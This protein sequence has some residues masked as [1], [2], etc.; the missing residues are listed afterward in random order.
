MNRRLQLVFLM[1]ALLYLGVWIASQVRSVHD[2]SR[3]AQLTN[4]VRTVCVGRYLVDVP[5][6]A[7][8]TLI[9]YPEY[10][11][12]ALT[13]LSM[14]GGGTEPCLL[15]GT[16]ETDSEA[17]FGERLRSIRLRDTKLRP[18]RRSSDTERL[19]AVPATAPNSL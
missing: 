18:L 10:A 17:G 19:E 2:R 9:G 15:A 1:A 4:R 14:P 16:V 12:V 13:F 8:V 3:V 6:Q 11:D 7:N 5:A